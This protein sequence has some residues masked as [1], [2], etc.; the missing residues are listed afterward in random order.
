MNG[1]WSADNSGHWWLFTKWQ[2]HRNK[3]EDIHPLLLEIQAASGDLRLTIG[4][5]KRLLDAKD[6]K[7]VADTLRGEENDGAEH[8]RESANAA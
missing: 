4:N 3:V 2:P 5:V 1:D 8:T 6:P 7:Q